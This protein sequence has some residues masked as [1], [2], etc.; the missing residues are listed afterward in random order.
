MDW[1]AELDQPA[2]HV[3]HASAGTPTAWRSVQGVL[4][5]LTDRLYSVLHDRIGVAERAR[6]LHPGQPTPRCA[7]TY[8]AVETVLQAVN[9]PRGARP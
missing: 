3:R 5:Q 8:L 9:R 1:A 4:G 2:G 7:L 6:A